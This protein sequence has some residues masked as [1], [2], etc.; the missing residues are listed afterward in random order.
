MFWYAIHLASQFGEGASAPGTPDPVSRRGGP[1]KP[2]SIT[3]APC[4]TY[5]SA[6]A[7]WEESETLRLSLGQA[8]KARRRG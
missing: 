1:G 4:R 7:E 3:S 2:K 6:G 5:P 8:L